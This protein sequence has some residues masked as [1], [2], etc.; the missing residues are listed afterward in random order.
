M[1]WISPSVVGD[2]ALVDEAVRAGVSEAEQL[3]IDQVRPFGT[4][5]DGPQLPEPVTP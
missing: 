2:Q 1:Q 4:K 5:Y 3:C